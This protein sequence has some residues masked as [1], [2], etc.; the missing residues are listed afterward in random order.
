[1]IFCPCPVQPEGDSLAHN[2]EQIEHIKSVQF[3]EMETITWL[4]WRLEMVG[5]QLVD[6][7]LSVWNIEF[8]SVPSAS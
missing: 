1:M 8:T 7:R 6:A 2:F 5:S 4:G 3:D